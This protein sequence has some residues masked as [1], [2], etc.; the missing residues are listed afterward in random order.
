MTTLPIVTGS[1]GALIASHNRV[2]HELVLQSLNG[3][4]RPIQHAQGGAEALVKLEERAWQVLFLDRRL[5]DLDCE[6]LIAIIQ[7]RF[8][9]IQVVLLDPD[10]IFQ[11]SGVGKTGQRDLDLAAAEVVQEESSGEKRPS[12]MRLSNVNL[13]PYPE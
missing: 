6:E 5:P 1:G 2:L 9:G 10:A 13:S 3:R 11:E 4:W 12:R 7:R 8:P